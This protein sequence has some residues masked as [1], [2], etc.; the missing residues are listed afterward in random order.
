MKFKNLKSSL[1]LTGTCFL[2][3]S[4]SAQAPSNNPPEVPPL[5]D[6]PGFQ[7]GYSLGKCEKTAPRVSCDQYMISG[8][9]TTLLNGT[10]PE[11]DI[12][13]TSSQTSCEAPG[14][15]TSAGLC[16]HNH[17]NLFCSVSTP[18]QGLDG[19]ESITISFEHNDAREYQ[20]EF[21]ANC[22]VRGGVFSG[23]LPEIARAVAEEARLKE[24]ARVAAA[25]AEAVR[26]AAAQ[27]EAV[28]VAAELVADAA[29]A[30]VAA[31]AGP[32]AA[33]LA[34]AQ[35]AP[36]QVAAQAVAAREEAAQAGAARGN[37]PNREGTRG[38]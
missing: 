21:E 7:A 1:F 29:P 10:H 16:D 12:R 26:V 28:R 17:V 32:A 24:E 2:V 5:P 27:A 8:L 25:Q 34:P 20:A 18:I 19:A 15:F 13:R 33:E 14:V 36:A 31:Y 23:T 30:Q 4:C 37:R 3:G 9:N 35:A 22:V 38:R 11:F 6:F